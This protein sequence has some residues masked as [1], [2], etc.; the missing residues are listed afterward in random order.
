MQQA[1]EDERALAGVYLTA[2]WRRDANNIL[3]LPFW[4]GGATPLDIQIDIDRHVV[5]RLVPRAHVAIDA[6]VD[7][8]VGGLR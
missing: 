6:G 3:F 1:S 7:H 2:G 5:G 8:P 4:E